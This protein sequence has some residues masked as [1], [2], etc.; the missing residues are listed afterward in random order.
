MHYYSFN[1][2][3]Y[4][5]DTVHLDNDHDLAYR[6]LLDLYYTSESPISKETQSV[7][8]RLRCGSN[9]VLDVLKE[10]F[11]ETENGWSQTRCDAEISIYH[12]KADVARA[13]GKC[14][15]R[16]KKTKRVILANRIGTGLQ[17]DGKLTKNYEL[18]TNNQP[19][20]DATHP[21]FDEFWNSY[22]KK[23]AK[24]EAMK[25]WIKAKPEI[26]NVLQ[27]LQWQKRSESWTKDNGQYVPHASTYLNQRR[28]EDQQPKQVV[29][30]V[31]HNAP[32]GG[33]KSC[34]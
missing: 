22:P 4:T 6:R 18:G 29:Q 12:R 17:P 5:L 16:P 26:A 27:T 3:A 1:P 19:K 15:G 11:T 14:G 28:F 21:G 7:A 13:N 8:I 20:K 31:T 34:L 25:S 2:S 10:F 30:S 24:A 9:V 33:W 23:T 32:A